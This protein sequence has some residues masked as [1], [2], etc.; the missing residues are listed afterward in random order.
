MRSLDHRHPGVCAHVL[1]NRSLFAEIVC[2]GIH[3]HPAMIRLFY[4]AKGGEKSILI[5]D[6]MAATGMPDGDYKLGDLDVRVA[7][8]KCTLVDAPETLAGSVLTMDGAVRNFAGFTGISLDQA[9]LLA[10][11]NPATLM[12]VE[13]QW[14]NLKVGREA[15]FVAL[16][17]D[18]KVISSFRRGQPIAV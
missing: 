4:E 14:G 11:R 7:Q 13:E 8:G 3:V 6:G 5:T 1:T 9:A 10:S 18:G 15:N 16:G 2:D 17:A 12:R